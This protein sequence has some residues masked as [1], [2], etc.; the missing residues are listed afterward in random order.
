MAEYSVT[1]YGIDIEKQNLS[2]TIRVGHIE[3]DDQFENVYDIRHEHRVRATLDVDAGEL[4]FRDRGVEIEIN[5]P[6]R[7]VREILETYP[8]EF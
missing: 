4:I 3:K 2:G 5:V 8:R 6:D 1:D 7:V